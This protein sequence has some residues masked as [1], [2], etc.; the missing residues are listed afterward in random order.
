MAEHGKSNSRNDSKDSVRYRIRIG[1]VSTSE[2]LPPLL[3][4]VFPSTPDVTHRGSEVVAQFVEQHVGE[5]S[6]LEVVERHAI[7]PPWE[8]VVDEELDVCPAFPCGVV[9]ER[10]AFCAVVLSA[11]DSFRLACRQGRTV[12]ED[13][14]LE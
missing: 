12:G 14:G 10:A 8:R 2:P 9:V 5:Q 1:E 4:C 3:G 13:D 7:G 11:T 6:I